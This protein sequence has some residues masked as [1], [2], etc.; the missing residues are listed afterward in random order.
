M[1]ALVEQQF[2]C[3]Y[4]SKK[5]MQE[6]TLAVHVCEQKRRA[7]ARNEKHVVLGYETFNQF[8]KRSQNFN[9]NKTYD[10]FARS[11]YYNAFVKFGSFISNVNPLYPDKFI[12]YVVTSGVRLDHWCR[13]ELYE[14]YVVALIRS[15]GVET[16]LERSIIHMQNWAEDNNAQWNHYFNY[17]SLNRATFDIKDGKVSP[18]LILNCASGKDMLK[19]LSDEQLTGIGNIIDLPF[20]LNKFKK[21]PADV[22]L[23]RQVAKES[24]L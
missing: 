12:D 6:K 24:N 7:L 3:Q 18:W 8:Y 9:G 13:D 22:V 2:T 5:F 15:E 16:A 17:V 21:L 23:V 19:K 11:S 10:E 20:W 1:I 14:K 4:C